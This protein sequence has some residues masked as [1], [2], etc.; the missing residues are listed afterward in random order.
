MSRYVLRASPAKL[1]ALQEKYPHNK[2]ERFNATEM[3]MEVHEDSED[4]FTDTCA[5]LGIEAE[6][7]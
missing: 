7:V 6:L 3:D 4:A 5:E 1:K 2:S